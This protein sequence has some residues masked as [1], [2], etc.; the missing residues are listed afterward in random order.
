MP[1]HW[2]E[3][4]PLLSRSAPTESALSALTVYK[5]DSTMQ[6]QI[7]T[8]EQLVDSIGNLTL[9]TSALNQVWAMK[10]LKT[11]RSSFPRLCLFLTAKLDR[12]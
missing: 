3:K 2:A 4:W 9:V 10:A 8:R 7:S 5:V 1:Q 6:E 11:K 12:P